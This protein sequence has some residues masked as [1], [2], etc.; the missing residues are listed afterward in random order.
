MRRTTAGLTALLLLTAGG[1]AGCSKPDPQ[2]SALAFVNGWKNGDLN[3]VGFVTAGGAKVSADEVLTEI[4]SYYGDLKDQPLSVTI[5]GD[6]KV[7]GDIATTPLDVAWTLPG[8]VTWKYQTSVRSILKDDDYQ[9]IWEP[10]VLSADLEQGEKFRLKRV[11][12]ERGT[13]LDGAGK[14]LISKQDVVVVG[15]TPQK[16][17]DI[18]ALTKSLTAAFKEVDVDIDLSGLKDQVAKADDGAFIDVVTLRRAAYDKIRDE[19]RPLSGTVFREESRLLAPTSYFARALLGQ[20]GDATKED[21]EKRPETLALGDQ[22]GHGGLQEKYD[23]QL[24][25][26]PGLQVMVSAEAADESVS[27]DPV[28]TSEPVT[29]KDITISIDRTVQT[30]ADAAVSTEKQPSSLVAIKVSDGS[31]LAVA[32][33]PDGTGVDTALTGQVPPGS[34]FKMISAYGLLQKGAVTPDTVV[35]CPKTRT[36]EG[37]TFKNSDGEVLGKVP[38]HV[39]FAKSCNTAFVGLSSKL[40]ADGLQS[41]SSALGIGGTW[42][43]GITAY[44]GKVSD[45]SS[46]TE[47]AAATFGQGSTA[48]SPVA[49]AAATAAVANGTFQAPKLVL[50]PAPQAAAAG[51]ALDADALTG[52]RSMMREVVTGG[53]GT[54]L[55][56]VPGGAVYG[57]T[58]T[59]EFEDGN[60]QTHSWFVGYQGDV[61]F[62]VM[63]QKGGAGSEA[64]VPIVK[65]FLASLS[66]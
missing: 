65:R 20:V 16:I 33:G 35:E 51:Q 30:A 14:A 9:V 3:D 53:T 38:F 48:V 15:V 6:P 55:K 45:G 5:A 64:A 25:G 41:A 19:V 24:R 39:D 50:D 29:G 11:T 59:A 60:E 1:L 18:A 10:A 4:K 54:G 17:K 57:K 46:A 49:M 22:V 23:D 63:V 8:G 52:L 34:T 66:K 61:A 56:G 21:L 26:A 27:E 28:F 2:D 37:R 32:N 43:L 13:I 12:A 44:T 36:V 58:G 7:Q 47:L 40:G 62:A 31:I 42:D